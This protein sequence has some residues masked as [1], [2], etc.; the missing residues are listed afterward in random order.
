MRVRA[1]HSIETEPAALAV[2]YPQAATLLQ[3]LDVTAPAMRPR[4]TLG[5]TTLAPAQPREVSCGVGA[6][7][8]SST[9]RRSLLFWQRPATLQYLLRLVATPLL[10]SFAGFNDAYYDYPKTSTSATLLFPSS[11]SFATSRP[12]RCSRAASSRKQRTRPRPRRITPLGIP[13]LQAHR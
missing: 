4:A 3:Q 7:R 1:L 5:S 10:E 6:T 2:D 13:L 11:T 9:S 8:R 12:D